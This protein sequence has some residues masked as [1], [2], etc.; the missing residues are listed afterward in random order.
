MKIAQ[1]NDTL[2]GF[3][4]DPQHSPMRNFM[5]HSYAI[6]FLRTLADRDW[7]VEN[8]VD[9]THKDFLKIVATGYSADIEERDSESRI[10]RAS[11]MAQAAILKH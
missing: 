3:G 7:A 8:G 10:L 6:K 2:V 1:A 5:D 4:E 11:N 9:P